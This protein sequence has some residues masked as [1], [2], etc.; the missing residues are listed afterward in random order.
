MIFNIDENN[1]IYIYFREGDA[2][3]HTV[4]PRYPN[5][6]SFD[7][8]EEAEAWANAYLAYE[9]SETAPF[10]PSGKGLQGLPRTKSDEDG[11]PVVWNEETQTWDIV[12]EPTPQEE[13][14]A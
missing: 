3:P 10:P 9:N 13:P 1:T 8:P 12:P 5:G 2:H 4:Q 6:D 14:S 7:S 11:N